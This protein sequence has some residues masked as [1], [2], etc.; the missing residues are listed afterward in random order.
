MPDIGTPD[1]QNTQS[2]QQNYDI[3]L[4]ALLH[5]NGVNHSAVVCNLS[6]F[7]GQKPIAR[8]EHKFYMQ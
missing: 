3:F 8:L 1:E 7:E 6:I 4:L 5:E 2:V